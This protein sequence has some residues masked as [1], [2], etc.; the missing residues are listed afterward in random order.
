M[1]AAS[2][3]GDRRRRS[4]RSVALFALV[5]LATS[6]GPACGHDWSAADA[7]RDGLDAPSETADGPDARPD[8]AMAPDD[9][10]PPDD[11]GAEAA[12]DTAGEAADDGTTPATC[13]DGVL[14]D[15]EACDDG[16]D[17][18]TDACTTG[19][20][21]AFCGD[22]FVWEGR[23]ECEPELPVSCVTLCDSFGSMLCG[24]DCRAFGEC[25]P[26]P[27]SC[28]GVD[29]DCDEIVDEGCEVIDGT[30]CATAVPVGSSGRYE[31]A[32]VSTTAGEV[33]S[34][35]DWEGSI[36]WLTFTLARR[37]VVYFDTLDGRS[38][39]TA[40]ELRGNDCLLPPRPLGCGD[41]AC[42]LARSQ[43][44]AVLEA[45]TYY[46][47]VAARTV[48]P[49]APLEVT[50]VYQHEPAF[51]GLHLSASG[52]YSGS[53]VGQGSDCAS[54]CVG[55]LPPDVDYYLALCA[56]RVVSASTCGDGT[57][58][59]T[60]LYA[61]TGGCAGSS[62][63]TELACN[64]DDDSCS[65]NLE[66]SSLSWTAPQGLSFLVVDGYAGGEG[67]FVLSISGL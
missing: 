61:R 21:I 19:C 32:F 23:E 5:S 18:D 52:S 64:N 25:V 9:A 53:T 20:R 37:E 22:G 7:D 10:S 3:A 35:A 24:D 11:A 14:D 39:D 31:L 30:T 1:S 63:A 67:D 40:L 62:T 33:L 45:G 49:G 50:L 2:G 54:T 43:L 56:P 4:S 27:E 60:L 13:G 29:D 66:A 34:C 48:G 42:G 17:L 55:G 6:A 38:G 16:N 47:V 44:H 57:S 59:D 15:G 36:L 58:F 8:D 28:N 46:L 26:P 51:S 41:D 65:A 12:D